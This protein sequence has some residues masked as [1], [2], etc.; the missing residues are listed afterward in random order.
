MD[1]RVQ[2]KE[3]PTAGRASTE[4]NECELYEGV[5]SV[6]LAE[7][8]R[9]QNKEVMVNLLLPQE[10]LKYVAIQGDVVVFTF[11]T[12][13]GSQ[14]PTKSFIVPLKNVTLPANRTSPLLE[15]LKRNL[16]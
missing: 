16:L 13:P 5:F 2:I 12:A 1:R 9:K 14:M 3:N 15:A 10:M 7:F 8:D 6:L 4:N 11:E